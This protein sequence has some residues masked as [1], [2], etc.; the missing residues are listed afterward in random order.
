MTNTHIH[1]HTESHTLSRHFRSLYYISVGNIL[2]IRFLNAKK[3]III[4]KIK[5]LAQLIKI[6][7]FIKVILVKI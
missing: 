4:I 2:A 5:I 3:K 6:K 7:I 1:T